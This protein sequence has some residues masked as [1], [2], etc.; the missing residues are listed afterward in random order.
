MIQPLTAYLTA[1]FARL[2]VRGAV[3]R[4]AAAFVAAVC[5]S[6][7][8]SVAQSQALGGQPGELPAPVVTIWH[9]HQLQLQYQQQTIAAPQWQ[10]QPV[11]MQQN[12]P[13]LQPKFQKVTALSYRP[14]LVMEPVEIEAWRLHWEQAQRQQPIRVWQPQLGQQQVQVW[15]PQWLP[16]T[17]AGHQ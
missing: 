10:L 6:S 14:R 11:W 15:R 9:P 8:T 7:Q 2:P 5:L 13:Y 3:A 12:I 1:V 4:V 17:P 16:V